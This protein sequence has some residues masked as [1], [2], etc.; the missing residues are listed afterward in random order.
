MF[1][2]KDEIAGVRKTQYSSHLWVVKIKIMGL[3][4][5]IFCFVGTCPRGLF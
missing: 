4:I 3:K 1:D 5:V 2:V